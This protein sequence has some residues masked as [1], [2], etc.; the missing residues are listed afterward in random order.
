MLR[1]A[2]LP[3]VAG[4]GGAPEPADARIVEDGA[5]DV[6]LEAAAA[7][8]RLRRAPR[9]VRSVL[10]RDGR[11]RCRHEM[12]RANGLYRAVRVP[13]GRHVIR[14]R[15]RPCALGVGLTISGMTALAL[16]IVCTVLPRRT[17][18]TGRSIRR[19]ARGFTLV[20]LMIVMAI[21]GIM[22]AIAFARYQSMQARGNESSAL[23]S[24]RSIAAAQWSSR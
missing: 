15:Y 4:I 9:L 5:N 14:F 19:G 10:A 17:S 13:A 1:L 6:T 3:D 22:L 12:V 2:W 18:R 24:M 8:R 23:A 11:R 20:E 21:I 7:G 16:G